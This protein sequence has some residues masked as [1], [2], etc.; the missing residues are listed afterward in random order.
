MPLAFARGEGLPW[1]GIWPPVA[2]ALSGRSPIS[3]E[4]IAGVLRHAAAFVVEALEADRSVYRLYHEALAEH[5]R[6]RTRAN[7][8]HRQ[9]AD[10]LSAIG[11]QDW[12]AAKPYIRTYLAEHAAAAGVLGGLLG[13]PVFLLAASPDRLLPAIEASAATMGP[14]AHGTTGGPST[15]CARDRSARLLRTLK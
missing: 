2:T 12:F 10:V 3:D 14:G 13:D 1:A 7:E 5:L 9:I 8:I 11:S 6:A 15:N 4:D